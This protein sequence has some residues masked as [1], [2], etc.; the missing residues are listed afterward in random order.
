MFNS[1]A[2]RASGVR[3]CFG[4]ARLTSVSAQDD[5][6]NVK[7]LLLKCLNVIATMWLR[8][9]VIYRWVE[10]VTILY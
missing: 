8:S 3:L 6:G 5:E 1:A 2:A 9:I 4:I 7:S 10:K